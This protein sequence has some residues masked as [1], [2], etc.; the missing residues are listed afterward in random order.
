MKIFLRKRGN[1]MKNDNEIKTI[2]R[3][4]HALMKSRGITVHDLDRICSQL[5]ELK[6]QA[7]G[8]NEAIKTMK[9]LPI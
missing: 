8:F 2:V 6:K 7:D 1:E 3:E 9:E 4:I 5:N